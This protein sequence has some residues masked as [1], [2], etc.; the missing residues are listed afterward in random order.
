MFIYSFYIQYLPKRSTTYFICLI[1]D[2]RPPAHSAWPEV[3]YG[4]SGSPLCMARTHQQS[5]NYWWGS[6]THNTQEIRL[7]TWPPHHHWCKPEQ[8]QVRTLQRN[9]LQSDK[10]KWKVIKKWYLQ[11]PLNFRLY[12]LNTSLIKG[13]TCKNF[14]VPMLMKFEKEGIFKNLHPKLN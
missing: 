4:W 10:I 5:D 6:Y 9:S 1:D 2:P 14:K 13:G 11:K 12:P 3:Y 7:A 8:Q